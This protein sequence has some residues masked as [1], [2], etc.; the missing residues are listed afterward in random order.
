MKN[1][2]YNFLEN[3]SLITIGFIAYL[4]IGI[5]GSSILYLLDYIT[6]NYDVLNH[7]NLLLGFTIS[8]LFT[9]L[10]TN[11]LSNIRKNEKF[12]KYS[13]QVQD[14]IDNAK[15]KKDFENIYTNNY[16]ELIN[17]AVGGQHITE[18]KR[19]KT[20]LETTLKYIK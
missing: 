16:P 2:I 5:F 4:V 7:K 12:W 13:E 20:I 8:I 3:G 1:K 9:I 14:L 18:V 15:T 11:V 10:F 19:I 17:L 6:F